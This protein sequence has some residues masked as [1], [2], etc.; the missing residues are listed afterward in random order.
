MPVSS[1]G[2]ERNV[3]IKTD[4]TTAGMAQRYR[5]R[6]AAADTTWDLGGLLR[7]NLSE[8]QFVNWA[9]GGT[10]AVGIIVD[11][12][13]HAQRVKDHI[14]WDNRAVLTYGAVAS[15]SGPLKKTE[16]RVEL[17]MR[18]GR[19]VGSGSRHFISGFGQLR[20]QLTE[21][22]DEATGTVKI[23]NFMT[24]GYLLFGIG[25]DYRIDLGA[26]KRAALSKGR[27]EPPRMDEHAGKL[28]Q[29]RLDSALFHPPLGV[30]DFHDPPGDSV[31][32]RLPDPLQ[33]RVDS[34]QHLVDSLRGRLQERQQ[35]LEPPHSR[36]KLSIFFSPLPAR[37]VFKQDTAFIRQDA[38]G[39]KADQRAALQFGCFM[40]ASLATDL[41]PSG[42]IALFTRLDLFS[43]YLDH[44]ENIVVNWEALLTF[45]LSK[46][47]AFSFNTLLVYDHNVDVSRI[48]GN[49][50]RVGPTT[51]FKQTLGLGVTTGF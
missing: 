6:R 47:V 34:L 43:N 10:S 40:S 27:I 25:T 37:M 23:S 33:L 48:V 19:E 14:A 45:R 50:T 1:M 2:Q 18:I 35:A 38:F 8:G 39:V 36:R 29:E 12:N 49:E 28:V 7:L 15:T 22:Y 32:A 51:Q 30:L 5:E 11:V 41:N 31:V 44:P 4:S 26:M 16:D 3:A 46:W 42:T 9:P 21:G 17:S 13:T 24:P 20:T